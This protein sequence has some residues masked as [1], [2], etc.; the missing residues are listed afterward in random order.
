METTKHLGL[1]GKARRV[2]NRSRAARLHSNRLIQEYLLPEDDDRPA[3]RFIPI[4]RRDEFFPSVVHIDAPQARLAQTASSTMQLDLPVDA[5]DAER[6]VAGP[7]RKPVLDAAI[8]FPRGTATTAGP[9]FK[10]VGMFEERRVFTLGGFLFG[11]ALGSA[12]AS[13]LLLVLRTAA[14]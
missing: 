8:R 1:S 14:G 10:P 13:F 11:C 6:I 7:E 3:D 2:R 12:A 4:G 5:A 9:V